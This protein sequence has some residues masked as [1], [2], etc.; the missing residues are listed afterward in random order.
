MLM[1]VPTY[2]ALMNAEHCATFLL[3]KFATT[4]GVNSV[5]LQN[6]S[7]TSGQI[8]MELSDGL[9]LLYIYKW[10]TFKVNTIQHGH[11]SQSTL[12]HTKP[13]NLRIFTDTALF[14][15]IVKHC[16]SQYAAIKEE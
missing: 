1:I 12:A 7:G 3:K 11:H 5:Y 4:T 2:T 14:H 10:L 8:S 6:I 13:D 16:F 15:M 9:Y